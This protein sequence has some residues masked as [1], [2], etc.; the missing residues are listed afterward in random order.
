V[1]GL[2]FY[3]NNTDKLKVATINGVVPT[4]DSVAKGEYPVSRPLYFYVKKAHLGVIPGLQEYIDF[5]VSDDIAGPDGPLAAYGLVPDP[6]LAATQAAVAAGTPM[7][8]LN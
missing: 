8:P 5:F 6:E 2:S 3:Q 1:F 4:V 7:G